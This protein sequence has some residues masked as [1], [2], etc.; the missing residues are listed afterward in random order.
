[1]SRA[2]KGET[3]NSKMIFSVTEIKQ[4]GRGLGMSLSVRFDGEYEGSGYESSAGVEPAPSRYTIHAVLPFDPDYGNLQ[5]GNRFVLERA[6]SLL[7]GGPMLGP[8]GAR[9]R[10]REFDDVS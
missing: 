5:I 7:T 1:M 3:M 9:I 6:S 2:V 8:D 4:L 10:I